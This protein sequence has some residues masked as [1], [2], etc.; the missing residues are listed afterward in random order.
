MPLRSS[1]FSVREGEE[2]GGASSG[3][4]APRGGG[5]MPGGPCVLVA[6]VRNPPEIDAGATD[7]M[8]SVR[9]SARAA[10]RQRGDFQVIISQSFPAIMQYD[11]S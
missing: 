6:A 1:R 5:D 2:T 10:A 8:E 9:V 4:G 3:D 11:L 7:I